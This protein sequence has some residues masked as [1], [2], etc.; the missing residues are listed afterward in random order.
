M[1]AEITIYCNNL[2]EVNRELE[3]LLRDHHVVVAE[4]AMNTWDNYD[5]RIRLT[6]KPNRL[7][8]PVAA[9]R[10]RRDVLSRVLSGKVNLVKENI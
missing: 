7:L 1:A 5:G 4:Q 6:A 9:E 3:L 8:V 2:E 10:R